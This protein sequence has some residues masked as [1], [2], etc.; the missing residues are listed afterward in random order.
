MKITSFHPVIMTTKTEDAISLFEELG[1]TKKHFTQFEE[2]GSFKCHDGGFKRL[3]CGYIL[4]REA[5]A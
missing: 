3:Y 4:G 5:A 1:F 2:L